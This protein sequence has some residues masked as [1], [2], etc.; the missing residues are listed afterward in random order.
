MANPSY[1]TYVLTIDCPDRRGI[2]RR[3]AHRTRPA[4]GALNGAGPTPGPAAPHAARIPPR[5]PPHARPRPTK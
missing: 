5:P 1:H 4:A 2:V 3:A